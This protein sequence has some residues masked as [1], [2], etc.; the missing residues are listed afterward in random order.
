MVKKLP[1][2]AQALSTNSLA[3]LQINIKKNHRNSWQQVM[4]HKPPEGDQRNGQ[5]SMD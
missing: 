5:K 4:T 1:I 2:L 3:I